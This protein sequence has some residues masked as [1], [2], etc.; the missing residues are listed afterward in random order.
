LLCAPGT[1]AATQQ[2]NRKNYH[3]GHAAPVCFE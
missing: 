3:A 2:E 1:G